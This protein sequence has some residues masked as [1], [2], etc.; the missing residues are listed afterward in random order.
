V[1]ARL[2]SS[3]EHPVAEAVAAG[4]QAGRQNA[5]QQKRQAE[6]GQN[7]NP[8]RRRQAGAVAER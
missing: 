5:M 3:N 7:G 2:Q 1:Q 4:R 6:N 8:G